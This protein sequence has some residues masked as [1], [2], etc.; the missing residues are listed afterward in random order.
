V[1]SSLQDGNVLPVSLL[2]TYRAAVWC[3]SEPVP[4]PLE[5]LF[6]Y[7]QKPYIAAPESLYFCRLARWQEH[8][9][10]AFPKHAVNTSMYALLRHPWLRK[11]LE[12]PSPP[13]HR[14][15]CLPQRITKKKPPG[16]DTR[17]GLIAM[18]TIGK[19]ESGQPM[20]SSCG[21]CASRPDLR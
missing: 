7:L 6:S 5:P 21:F 8:V 20:P 15:S 12:R 14:I 1:T 13:A 4:D 2:S 19:P 11:V 17:G 9:G 16:A 18:N 10:K 3:V